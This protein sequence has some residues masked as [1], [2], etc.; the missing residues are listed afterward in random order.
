MKRELSDAV[1][2]R[3][4]QRVESCFVDRRQ[5]YLPS[6]HWHLSHAKSF[7]PEALGEMAA[8]CRIVLH[9][10]TGRSRSV[11]GSKMCRPCPPATQI[12][13]ATGRFAGS[14]GR[15]RSPS[16]LRVVQGTRDLLKSRDTQTS[17]SA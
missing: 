14:S 12:F 8:I 10:P 7:G 6:R 2:S 5:L 3:T 17:H 9:E 16:H 15:A 1:A 13:N 11:I 4:S